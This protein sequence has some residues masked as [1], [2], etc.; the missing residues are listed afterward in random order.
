M[1]VKIEN[2]DFRKTINQY[3]IIFLSEC[4]FSPK[5][6]IELEG[7][8]P[9]IKARKRKKRAK[10]D[11][12]GLCVLVKNDIACLFEN[13]FYDHEDFIIFKIS[14]VNTSLEKDLF[15]IFSYMRPSS[16]TRNNLLDESDGYD[17]LLKK[18]SELRKDNELIIIGD[19]NSRCGILCDY[20]SNVCSNFDPLE[21]D[22]L[23]TS[24]ISEDDLV[25]HNVPITR[26]NE[27]LKLNDFGHKL[28]NLCKVTGLLICKGRFK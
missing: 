15:L 13:V 4:W 21:E 9:V 8:V 24:C 11:S 18:V 28:I 2:P 3:D 17:M 27:D 5:T 20:I 23:E 10:R 22:I 16:S 26:K 12:G 7:F 14:Q 25:K 1:K 6:K 19:L